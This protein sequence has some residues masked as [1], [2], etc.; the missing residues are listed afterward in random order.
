M[1]LKD[2]F[3]NFG[4]ITSAFDLEISVEKNYDL[5]H[6]FFSAPDFDDNEQDDENNDFYFSEN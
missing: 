3:I 4:I 6:L 2:A 1:F 5:L